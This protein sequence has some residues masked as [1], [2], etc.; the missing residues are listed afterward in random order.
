MRAWRFCFAEA[1]GSGGDLGDVET[2]VDHAPLDLAHDVVEHDPGL[3]ELGRVHADLL[4]A[5]SGAHHAGVLGGHRDDAVVDDHARVVDG[6]G[7]EASQL[8]VR[9][10]LGVDSLDGTEPRPHRGVGKA[11]DLTKHVVDEF[12]VGELGDVGLGAHGRILWLGYRSD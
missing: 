10:V 5:E 7:D 8:L 11:F 12:L 9:R 2:L 1:E 4:D 3:A 6:F